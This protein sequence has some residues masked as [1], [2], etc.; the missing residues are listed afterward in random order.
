MSDAKHCQ[1]CQAQIDAYRF[2]IR[3]ARASLSE[4]RIGF[5]KTMSWPNVKKTVTEFLDWI[6][7]GVTP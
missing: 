1:C 4:I 5:W 7:F 6:E 3:E 2:R